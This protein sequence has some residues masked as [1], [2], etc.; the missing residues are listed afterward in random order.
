M[1]AVAL[2]PLRPPPKRCDTTPRAQLQLQLLCAILLIPRRPAN[3]SGPWG[4]HAKKR[5]A[6]GS[7]LDRGKLLAGP[8]KA[9]VLH[10]GP[11]AVLEHLPHHVVQVAWHGREGIFLSPEHLVVYACAGKN[12]WKWVKA[13]IEICRPKEVKKL[14]RHRR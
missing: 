6:V 12:R 7:H 10:R 3:K 1:A 8:R 9:A 2:S 11:A 4:F 5:D 14:L 13:S